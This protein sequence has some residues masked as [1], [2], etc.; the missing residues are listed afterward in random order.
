MTRP[1]NLTPEQKRRL[2]NLEPVLR[3]A[4]RRGDYESAKRVTA[5]IQAVLR[6]TGHETRLMK[7]KNWLFEAALEA[8]HINSV[9]IPGFEGV[10]RKTDP[11][12]R[13]YLEATALLAICHLRRADF[14]AAEPYMAESIQK[15]F[16]IASP[17]R[18][19][20]FRR[21]MIDRFEREW[22]I[23]TLREARQYEAM[24]PDI[25]QSQ[26]GRLVASTSDEDIYESVGRS[27]PPELVERLFRVYDFARNQVPRAEQRYLPSGQERRRQKEVGRTLTSAVKDVVWRSLCDP[28]SDVYKL[29]YGVS[30]ELV[31]NKKVVGTAVVMAL[32]GLGIGWL[33]LAASVTAL[34]FKMG[35]EVFCDMTKPQGLMIGLDE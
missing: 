30:I 20:Q 5:E 3:S 18:R 35:L 6:P 19:A 12:T 8:G 9:A 25:V 29:W 1:P 16:N 2:R 33:A 26:A 32:G 28:Q 10:R 15:E 13:V 34:I 21:R 27:T 24:D 4:A 14:D 11:K 23:A 7:A 31:V 22:V 17:Q